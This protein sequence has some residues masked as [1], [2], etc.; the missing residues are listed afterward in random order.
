VD[1]GKDGSVSTAEV[2]TRYDAELRNQYGNLASRTFGMLA[3]YRDG[4][5]PSAEVDPEVATGFADIADRVCA[6]FDAVEPT[7]AL[8]AVWE[9][10][11]R[12]NQYVQDRAPWKLAKED[13]A[14]AELDT[15]LYTLVEGLRVA[16]LLSAPVLPETSERLLTALGHD[17]LAL[18]AARLG[19]VEGGTQLGDLGQ[20]FPKVEPA[21]RVEA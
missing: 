11:R 12:L 17:D 14:A 4:V 16:A 21:E 8:G 20:L 18:G 19:A 1:F 5:V 3:Q 10:V 6:H 9:L 7:Q 13:G 2:E 15:V